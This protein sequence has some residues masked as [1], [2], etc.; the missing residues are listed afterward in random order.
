MSFTMSSTSR[1][2]FWLFPVAIASF[3]VHVRLFCHASVDSPP[4]SNQPQVTL[5]N[6]ASMPLI[7]MG[8]GNLPHEGIPDAVIA[9]LHAGVLIIDTAHASNNERILGEAIARYD[10]TERAH[11]LTRGAE[12]PP[13]TKDLGPL[14]VVTKVWYTH[15]GYERTKISVQES[16]EGL[17]SATTRQ[18][19]VHMLIHWPRCDDSIPWMH[20]EEEEKNLPQ[21]VKDAGPPPHLDKDN[22][23]KDS[24]RA[25]EDIYAEHQQIIQEPMKSGENQPIITSIGVSNF[26]LED[27][28]QLV[29]SN[30]RTP[31]Q[32]YQGN[33]WL[34]FHD[35]FLMNYLRDNNIAFQAYAVINGII[36]RKDVSPNAFNVLSGLSR[37]LMAT[38][39]SENPDLVITEATVLLAYFVHRN[40][41]VIPRAASS[42]HRKENSPRALSAILPHLT[43]S[44]IRQL[45]SAIPALMKGEDVH[46]SVSFTNG[47]DTPIQ[48]HWVNPETNEEV[49]VSNV[50]HP[51][52][53]EG[54]KSHPGHRFV[55]YDPDRSI[56][57]E[58]VVNAEYG[59]MQAFT[60]EL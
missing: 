43:P 14:H 11:G 48:I 6:G 44:H 29:E 19:Y 27:L 36:Q 40:V 52:S 15:L 23:F 17:R 16:L 31:P 58:F 22:A 57:K 5:E 7:G 56:R 55:A 28:K 33:S 24:W 18:V 12:A 54:Q 42:S 1:P 21:S 50:I 26:E 41:G 37:D 8:I 53:S 49:L 38:I 60:V 9:N 47:L 45:E 3:S 46:T 2:R 34:L 13:G 39:Y 35:P 30:P 25:L 10:S 4:P 51:G 20:C 32:L 59:E